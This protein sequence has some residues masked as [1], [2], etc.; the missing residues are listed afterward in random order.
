MPHT[1][2]EKLLE[3]AIKGRSN[4]VQAALDSNADINVQCPV[5]RFFCEPNVL[6]MRRT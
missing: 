1:P 5:R 4:A 3:A 2:E 6:L